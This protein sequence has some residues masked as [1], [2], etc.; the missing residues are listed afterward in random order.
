MPAM[1]A[2]GIELREEWKQMGN[3]YLILYCGISDVTA[4]TD[5]TT[6]ATPCHLSRAL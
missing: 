5:P 6:E 4:G 2:D 3:H 1:N